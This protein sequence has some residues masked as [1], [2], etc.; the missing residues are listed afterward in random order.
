MAGQDGA[1]QKRVGRHARQEGTVARRRAGHLQGLEE[2][3]G[4]GEDGASVEEGV[5]SGGETV[6]WGDWERG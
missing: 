6:P 5:E 3:V 4:E 2:H 1:A